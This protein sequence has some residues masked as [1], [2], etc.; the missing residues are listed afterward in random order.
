MAGFKGK[1]N[2]YMC[3]TCGRGVVTVDVD[4]GTTPFAIPCDAPSCGGTATSFFYRA[5]QEMLDGVQPAFEWYR[6]SAVELAGKSAGT[7]DHVERGGLLMRPLAKR[8]SAKEVQERRTA[9]VLTRTSSRGSGGH[10]K[11]NL[12]GLPG[13]PALEK[14]STDV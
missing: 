9:A 11:E 12:P 8:L 7:K 5:P 1:K 4:D 2:I 10:A 13:G 6:P 3:P 14:K